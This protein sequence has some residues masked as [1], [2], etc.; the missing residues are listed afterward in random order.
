MAAIEGVAF[1]VEQVPI[2][3]S[4]TEAALHVGEASVAAEAAFIV[5]TTAP[6]PA[7]MIKVNIKPTSA[8]TIATIWA[9]KTISIKMEVVVMQL[10]LP[11]LSTLPRARQTAI[12]R[13]TAMLKVRLKLRLSES[14]EVGRSSK[15]PGNEFAE[16]HPF[17]SSRPGRCDALSFPRE[18]C[19]YSATR[20]VT[21]LH[22]A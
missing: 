15:V 18:F 20:C 9:H 12:L 22:S 11:P 19:S 21:W 14:S 2:D 3:P 10:Q 13:V 6:L 16:R 8:H 7:P 4:I 17:I 5:V 1:P